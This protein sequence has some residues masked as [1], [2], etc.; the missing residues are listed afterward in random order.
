MKKREID[1]VVTA[2]MECN[3][4]RLIDDLQISLVSERH[5]GY[6]LLRYVPA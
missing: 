4:V 6:L 3:F 1:V 2:G 5:I